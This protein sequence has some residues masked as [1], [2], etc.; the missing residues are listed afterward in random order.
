VYLIAAHLTLTLVASSAAV[1]S[2]LCARAAARHAQ[3]APKA[4]DEMRQGFGRVLDSLGRMHR[5]L[6]ILAELILARR[7]QAPDQAAE[8]APACLPPSCRP[9]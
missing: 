3:R 7:Q 8:E 4:T 2:G 1:Y 9:E 6:D 5:S